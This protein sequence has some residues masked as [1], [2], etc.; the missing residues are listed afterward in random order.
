MDTS[1][2][3]AINRQNEGI[4]GAWLIRQGIPDV[5][6]LFDG[7]RVGIDRQTL[8]Q[9]IIKLQDNDARARID[10]R[11][12]PVLDGPTNLVLHWCEHGNGRYKKMSANDVMPAPD[13]SRR[14][15]YR[16]VALGASRY[17]AAGLVV[18][19]NA[20]LTAGK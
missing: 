8:E 18:C 14:V 17:L 6:G 10:G 1:A 11:Q 13:D 16:Q 19:E 5:E 7:A 20:K 2:Q 15:S 4:T 3:S 9:R 12:L